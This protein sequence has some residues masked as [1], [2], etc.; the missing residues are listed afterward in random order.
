MHLPG[1]FELQY[2]FKSK[3]IQMDAISGQ[4]PGSY[5]TRLD[6]AEPEPWQL[7]MKVL[8]NFKP[9]GQS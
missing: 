8:R 2:Q 7:S 1:I 4:R 5:M 9:T 6:T 3:G